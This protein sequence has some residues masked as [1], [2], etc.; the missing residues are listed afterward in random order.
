MCLCGLALLL[1]WPKLLNEPILSVIALGFAIG[2]VGLEL[3]EVFFEP[4]KEIGDLKES[5]RY[6]SLDKHKLRNL[7]IDTMRRLGLSEERIS[8]FVTGDKSMNAKA[9]RIGILSFFKAFNG[10]YLHR[11]LLHKLKDEEVQAVMGHELGHIYR[12]FLV[13][14]R[15]LVVTVGLGALL[16]LYLGQLSGMRGTFGLILSYIVGGAFWFFASI[17]R[18]KY[19]RVIEFLCDDFGAHVHGVVPSI[20]GILKL[21]VEAELLTEITLQTLVSQKDGELGPSDVLKAVQAAI[22][23][24]DTKR[25]ELQER[26][27]KTIEAREVRERT[28]SIGGFLKY[29]WNAD[30]D[31]DEEQIAQAEEHLKILSR[32]ERIPWEKLL[33]DPNQV[34]FTEDDLPILIEL[35]E[36]RPLQTL[37]RMM[38]EVAETGD[39]QPRIRDRILYLWK[40]R[41]EIE[42]DLG[43]PQRW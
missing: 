35:I 36:A 7:Q 20:N 30:G 14:D 25:D 38:S 37:F 26:I 2:P 22:P 9:S 24:G 10:I 13:N 16:G 5:T 21:G 42:R 17:P 28:A 27:Q 4:K 3:L 23:Y 1:D 6:G 29:F 32:F 43:R 34:A 15:M 8:V 12:Y 19:A 18:A 33:E 41:E 11:Q 31:D 40:H 39:A